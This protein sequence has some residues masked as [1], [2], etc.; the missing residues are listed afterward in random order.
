[1][2]LKLPSLALAAALSLPFGCATRPAPAT[3]AAPARAFD[4]RRDTVAFPNELVWAYDFAPDGTRT[5]MPRKPRPEYAHRCFV[6]ARLNR[7]FFDHAVFAPEQPPPDEAEARRLVRSVRQRPARAPSVPEERV[8]IPGYADLHAFSSAHEAAFKAGAGTKAESYLQRG[9]W[10][11]IAPFSRGHQAKEAV[12]L[13]G[14][15][16]DGRPRVIHLVTFPSLTMNHAVLVHAVRA[17]PEALH[18]AAADPNL[19]GEPLEL[20]FDRAGRTFHW[21]RTPYFP[22]GTVDA[23]EVYRGAWY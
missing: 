1:M 8:V 19:P 9:H 4:P 16:A 6:V 12:R 11:M 2:P 3:D 21:P 13:E 18:F 15:L 14:G 17:T 20:S 10:R 5:T 7:Q 22:G 23:Y